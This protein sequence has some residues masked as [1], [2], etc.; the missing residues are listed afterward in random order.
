MKM[1]PSHV[2]ENKQSSLLT[3][4]ENQQVFDLLGAQCQ[5]SRSKHTSSIYEVSVSQMI[6]T[7][8][9]GSSNVCN[10]VI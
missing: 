3:M 5:V 10:S 8:L 1:P 4:D 2:T 6:H 9:L 7:S